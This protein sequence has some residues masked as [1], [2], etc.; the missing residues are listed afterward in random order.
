MTTVY[1]RIVSYASGLA[2]AMATFTV[3]TPALGDD[4]ENRELYLKICSKC[5]GGINEDQVSERDSLLHFVVTMPLG[6]SLQDIYGRPAGIYEGY[7]YSP[8][9]QELATGWAWDD[10]T[11]DLWLT[12]SQDFVSGSTMV[13]RVEDPEERAKVIDYLK[14]YA[15]YEGA[16]GQ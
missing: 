9:F 4:A 12:N 2:A 14:K 6:P 16:G 7:P 10:E 3:A 8:A 1:Q 13:L 11:L 15:V 5:H